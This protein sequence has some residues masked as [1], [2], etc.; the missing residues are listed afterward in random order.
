MD[1]PEDIKALSFEEALSALETIV[2]KL[3]KGQVSL[4]DSID[5]YTRGT[6]LKHHCDAKLKDAETRIRKITT[7]PDG[8][9]AA[10]PLDVD[11]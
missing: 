2:Q 9:L 1:I 3:E 4:E 8:A 6:Y 11:A 10:Q 7:G 5:I